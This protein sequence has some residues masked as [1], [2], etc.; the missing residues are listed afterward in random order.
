MLDER[1]EKLRLPIYPGLALI[2]KRGASQADGP[3]VDP[4]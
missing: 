1:F 3:I 4:R 2:Q